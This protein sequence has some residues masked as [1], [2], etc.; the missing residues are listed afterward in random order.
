MGNIFVLTT[1][2]A[3]KAH[4]DV[5]LAGVGVLLIKAAMANMEI[6]AFLSP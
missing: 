1:Q 5:V 2:V 4:P 3:Y 6:V